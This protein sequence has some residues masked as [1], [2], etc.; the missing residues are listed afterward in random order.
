M[1]SGFSHHPGMW[2]LFKLMKNRKLTKVDN[3]KKKPHIFFPPQTSYLLVRFTQWKPVP[4]WTSKI[5]LREI[6]DSESMCQKKYKC[7]TMCD[8]LQ[9]SG[10]LSTMCVDNTQEMSAEI[11]RLRSA[12]QFLQLRV[13]VGFLK[14]GASFH[15]KSKVQPRPPPW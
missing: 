1:N 9:D 15:Y 11:F 3:I 4:L 6:N 8:F 14:P 10:K 5:T 2:Y 12:F 7:W 13:S